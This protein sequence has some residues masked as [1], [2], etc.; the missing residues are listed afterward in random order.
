MKARFFQNLTKGMILIAFALISSC[1][2]E[3]GVSPNEEEENE[4]VETAEVTLTPKQA[5]PGQAV[6]ITFNT[7]T[8]L[9][10][11]VHVPLSGKTLT[12]YKT[13]NN[14]YTGIT[15]VLNP[16]NHAIKLSS[17]KLKNPLALEI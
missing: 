5:V 4:P 11:T 1:G 14:E 13:G 2:K 6:V 7:E 10:D 8:T 15:P 17:H 3:K 9:K 12:L 16:G